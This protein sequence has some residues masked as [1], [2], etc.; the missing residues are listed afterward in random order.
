MTLRFEFAY[1]GG[2]PGAGGSGLIF[3]NG[4]E[5]ATGR[6]EHTHPNAFGA[7][8]TDVGENLYTVVTDD[9]K[10]GDNK[11]TGKIDKVTIQV[12]KSNLSEEA[13]RAIEELRVKRIAGHCDTLHRSRRIPG[14]MNSINISLVV[15]TIVFGGAMLGMALSRRLPDHYLTPDS[16]AHVK[17]GASLLT[18]MFALLLS[19]QLSSGKSAFDQQEREVSVMASKL[20]LLDRTLFRY[21]PAATDARAVLRS[22]IAD[23]LNQGWPQE[24]LQAPNLKPS[25][26]RRNHIRQNSGIDTGE[27]RSTSR[28]S[29]GAQYSDRFRRIALVSCLEDTQFHLHSIDDR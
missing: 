27:R 28:E 29:R 18:S 16:I 6:I 7:E 10:V 2:R 3:V 21:G 4:E 12:G 8:T 24:R 15:L 23:M 17:V 19:L 11:F 20:A 26:R 22:S 1:D 9:Y 14:A 25:D 13:Q 5:V